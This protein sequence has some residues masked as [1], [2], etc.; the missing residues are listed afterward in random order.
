MTK[1]TDTA[2]AVQEAQAVLDAAKRAHVDAQADESAQ[3]KH[4]RDMTPAERRA[5]AK[6]LGITGP[7]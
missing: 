7:L 6:R 4:V 5:D 2:R 1:T 3:R